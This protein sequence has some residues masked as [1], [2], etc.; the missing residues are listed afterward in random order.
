MNL[1]LSV[2][3]RL[4]IV[5][6]VGAQKPILAHMRTQGDLYE[7]LK[8]DPDSEQ[9]RRL[10]LTLDASGAQA[11]WKWDAEKEKEHGFGVELE[12]AEARVLAEMIGNAAEWDNAIWYGW[13][14]EK[15]KELQSFAG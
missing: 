8:I 5:E 13:L 2:L 6:K 3:Q 11:F 4:T 14:W 15:V 9:V 7:K 12:R 1:K 10:G